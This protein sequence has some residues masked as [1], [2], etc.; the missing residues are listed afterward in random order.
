MFNDKIET[1]GVLNIQLFD[2]TGNLKQSVEVKNLV[3]TAGK[4]FIASR[5]TGTSSAVMG[6]MALGTNAT[7]ALVADTTLG[8]E[9]AGSRTALTSSIP[10]ANVVAYT[11]TFGPGVGT[12]SITEAG[13]L[14]A[15][16]VGTLLS[17][18]VFATLTKLA[19]DTLTITWNVTIA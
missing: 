6:W 4:A 11:A 13:I 15:A 16:T 2:E 8:T 18:T 17:H 9:A 7:A 12:G 1:T 14:N 19:A 5:I 10:T 3:T